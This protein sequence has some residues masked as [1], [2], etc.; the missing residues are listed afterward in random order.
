MRA[1][2]PKLQLHF[3]RKAARR[4]VGGRFGLLWRLLAVCALAATLAGGQARAERRVALV[5]GNAAYAGA[6]LPSTR[7]DAQDIAEALK[8]LGFEIVLGLDLDHGRFA[9]TFE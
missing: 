7:N 6:A 8:K 2:L 5:V 3:H 9:G 4:R 1:Q